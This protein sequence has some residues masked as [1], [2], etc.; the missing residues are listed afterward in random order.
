VGRLSLLRLQ[1]ERLELVPMADEH[2]ALVVLLNSDPEVMRFIRGRAATPEETLAEWDVRL[3][4]QTDAA[5][6]LGYWVGFEDGAF[7][8]W[9]S[10]SSYAKD[11]TVAGLGYRLRRTAWGRGLA[12]EGASAM[13][14]QGFACADV[15]RVVA[16]TMAANL[17]SRRVLE[18]VGLTLDRVEVRAWDDPIPGWEQG[19]AYYSLTRA[20]WEAR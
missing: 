13:V 11:P 17:G 2:R 9:W 20:A 4:A 14:A 12:S 16:S 5:R 7:V 18:A 19:E 6:G 15:Q 1:T 3:S 8:G 10:A